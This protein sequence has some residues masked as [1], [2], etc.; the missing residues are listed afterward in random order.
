MF[1][2]IKKDFLLMFSSKITLFI[3][4]L[5]LP[6]YQLLLAEGSEFPTYLVSIITLGYMLTTMSFG[7]ETKNKSYIMLR[8]LPIKSRDIVIAKYIHIFINYIIAVAYTFFYLKLL[9]FFNVNIPGK[10]NISTL[11]QA[12]ILIVLGL[13]I[14]I[15]LQFKL[16]S[17]IANFINI[18]I[19][20]LL[21]NH[22]SINVGDNLFYDLNTPMLFGLTFVTYFLS[23][24]ISLLLYRSRDLS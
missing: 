9:T 8:S 16:P 13:C 24:G 1:N 22:F 15:P 3:F 4:L 19:Y 2:L 20:I 12:F 5:F 21:M 7:F 14:S 6:V 17:N 18:F 23:I 10:F 11:K